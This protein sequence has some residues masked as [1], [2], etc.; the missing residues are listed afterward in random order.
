[1][2]TTAFSVLPGLNESV[3][4]IELLKRPHVRTQAKQRDHFKE[5]H[6]PII[7]G[8]VQASLL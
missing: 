7:V 4:R 2:S 8:D 6:G 1:M 3:F 5:A